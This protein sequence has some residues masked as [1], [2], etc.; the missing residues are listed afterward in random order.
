[1]AESKIHNCLPK[2]SIVTPSYNQGQ[3]IEETVRSVLLQ[4]YPNL[5]YIIIDGG[6]MDNS[7][8]IIRRYEN[9]ISYW[10]SEPDEGQA[11]A[12]NKG[13]KVAKGEWLGWL[14][15]DDVY[16]DGA[17]CAV[18]KTAAANPDARLIYGDCNIITKGGR[19]VATKSNSDGTL[20]TILQG[21]NL[22][23]PAVFIHRS[24]LREVGFLDANYHYALDWSFHLRCF[25]AYSPEKMVYIPKVLANSREYG[26][27]KTRT[28]IAKI[29][30]ERRRFLEEVLAQNGNRVLADEQRLAKASTY[31]LQALLEFQNREYWPGL[32]SLTK[33]ISLDPQSIFYRVP[34]GIRLFWKKKHQKKLE[35]LDQVE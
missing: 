27:T 22:S 3:F 31:W 7:V 35:M 25:L 29:S 8:E 23:Q 11:D 4:D 32:I 18:A 10:V 34:T 5:E 30:Q 6:S 20:R 14:N 21:K 2:I 13:Y 12:V 1:M 15:S 26:E 33:A 19:L 16:E 24:V 17:L 9:Q 28:G